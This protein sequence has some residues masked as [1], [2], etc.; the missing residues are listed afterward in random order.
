MIKAEI[1]EYDEGFLPPQYVVK[2]NAAR[3]KSLKEEN[4]LLKKAIADLVL[5]KTRLQSSLETAK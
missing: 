5:E 3:L 4:A 1:E 2:K